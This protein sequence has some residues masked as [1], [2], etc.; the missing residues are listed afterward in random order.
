MN[1]FYLDPNPQLAAEYHCDKH[2]VKM[3][4]EYSQLLST[5]HRILDGTMY[6]DKTAN[7]RS[8]KRWRH[9]DENMEKNLCLACHVNHPSAIWTRSNVGHYLWLRDL[10]DCLVAEYKYRY[11]NKKHATE[12][13]IPYLVKPPTNIPKVSWS[14][15]PPAMKHY[16]QCIVRGNVVESYR[17]YY[18]V[19]KRSFATWKKRP[20]PKWYWAKYTD[21]NIQ[22]ILIREAANVRG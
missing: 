20:D 8:I 3:I 19:A 11:N 18:A 5:A 12:L 10:L 16:P 15:P 1:I 22:R 9:P 17:N 13:R 4:V 6:L 21:A 14:D 2:V 7:G